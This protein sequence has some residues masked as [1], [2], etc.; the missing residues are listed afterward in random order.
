LTL[1]ADGILQFS[2]QHKKSR[3]GWTGAAL[4]QRRARESALANDRRGFFGRRRRAAA[5][6]AGESEDGRE[7]KRDLLH[8]NCPKR[9]VA[10]GRDSSE[11]YA[12][13]LH[14]ICREC[15]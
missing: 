7:R 9:I 8:S 12:R 5:S 1:P 3:A 6:E 14:E 11:D 10:K 4:K 15:R 2:I 13:F